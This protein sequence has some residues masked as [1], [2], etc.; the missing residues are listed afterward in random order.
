MFCFL[1]TFSNGAPAYSSALPF[2]LRITFSSIQ[3][4]EAKLRVSGRLKVQD[5]TISKK[6]TIK[7]NIFLSYLLVYVLLDAIVTWFVPCFL[8]DSLS[9]PH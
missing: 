1:N 4:A 5:K 8:T 7:S 2:L 9:L 3:E 6:V